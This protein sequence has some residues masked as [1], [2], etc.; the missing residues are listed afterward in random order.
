MNEKLEIDH[1]T[2]ERFFRQYAAVKRFALAVSQF[3]A[4]DNIKNK[5]RLCFVTNLATE[6]P[7]YLGRCYRYLKLCEVCANRLPLRIGSPL[8]THPVTRVN[9][10]FTT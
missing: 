8:Y 3:P 1:A 5:S 10:I 9:G 7:R 2:P 4:H 6:L